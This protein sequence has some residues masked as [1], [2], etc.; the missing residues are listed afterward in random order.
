MFE[1]LSSLLK[2]IFITIIYIFLFSI[3]RLI[4][5]DIRSV[6]KKASDLAEKAPYLK[7]INRRDE[8]YFKVEESYILSRDKSL[9][10]AAKANISIEDPFLSGEHARF[11]HR[12]G[13]ILLKDLGSKNGTLIN[14]VRL[15][16]EEVPLNNGDKIE[17]GQLAFLFVDNEAG[18]GT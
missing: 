8:L 13:S 2:Y 7:L 16:D 10:R 9:G 18:E 15:T 3:I 4:Y 12:D 14:G 6:N 1:I 17:M 5:L 11:I